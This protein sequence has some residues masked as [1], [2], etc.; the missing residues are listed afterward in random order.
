MNDFV[1]I[2]PPHPI[3]SPCVNVCRIDPASRL[4]KGCARTI[5]EIV[6]WTAMT[7][8]ERDRVMTDLAGRK[9]G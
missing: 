1:E 2:V 7:A 6:R 5:E 4:C 3:V 9:T 8:A